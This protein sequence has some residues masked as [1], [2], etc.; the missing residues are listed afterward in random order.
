MLINNPVITGSFTVNGTN[1]I[2]NT[3][4]TGSNTFNG[5]QIISGSAI[6]TG[7][8]QVTGSVTTTGTIT[9]QTL[10]VSTISSSIE[11]ASGSNIFGSSLSNRQQMTGSV[12]I[13]GSFTQTGANTTSSFA[14]LVGI[15]TSSPVQKLNV[16]GGNIRIDNSG[17]TE[18][19]IN[20]GTN[21]WEMYM[22]SG[23]NDLKFYRGTDKM[24][25]T[26]TGNVGIGTTSPSGKLHVYGQANYNDGLYVSNPG[27]NGASI[28]LSSTDTGGLPF[29]IISTASSNGPGAGTLSIYDGTAYRFTLKSGNVGIGTDNP[30][31][32]LH[33]NSAADTTVTIDSGGTAYSSTISFVV[34]SE[35]AKIIGSYGSG[36]GGNLAFNVDSTGGSD[37]QRMVLTNAG[38]LRL[39]GAGIQF[40]GDTADANSLD[41]YEEGSWSPTLYTGGISYTTNSATYIKIG[42]V[43]IVS[44]YLGV[45]AGGTATAVELSGLPF[46]VN[47]GNN[48]FPGAADLSKC[49]AIGAVARAN[50]NSTRISFQV[51]SG[52]TSV[53]RLDVNGNQFGAGGYIIFTVTYFTS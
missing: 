42:R 21:E 14:G 2:T 49:S 43:V 9:A 35:R 16:N 46:S 1:F 27:L 32:A 8:L 39:A 5:N 44:A 17:L 10:V 12:S 37:I 18:F 15:G 53:D 51:S 25:L 7:S 22:S 40:N 50:N 34:D 33:V 47:S 36:G 28:T 30:S 31:T 48:F 26:S 4:S 11:Y 38:Y 19:I 41:D 52:S 13:T 6:V 24:T 3:P 29:T 20:N 45:T 23:S